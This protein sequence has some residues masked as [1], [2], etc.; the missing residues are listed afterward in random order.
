MFPMSPKR[1]SVIDT[2]GLQNSSPTSKRYLIIPLKGKKRRCKYVVYKII[3][4]HSYYGYRHGE[5]SVMEK[6]EWPAKEEM[7]DRVLRKW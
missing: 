5:D 7:Q 1:V 3:D 6:F 2:L 4:A